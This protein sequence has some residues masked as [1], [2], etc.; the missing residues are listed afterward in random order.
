VLMVI[1]L[2]IATPMAWIVM[3]KWLRNFADRTAISWWIF[4]LGAL[5]MIIISLFTLCFQ[6][7]RAAMANPVKGLRAD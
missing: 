2:A 5:L 3:N 6:T 1:A 4:V 7:V